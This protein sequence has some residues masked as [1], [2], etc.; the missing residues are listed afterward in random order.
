[1]SAIASNCESHRAELSALL[2]GES[3]AA[4]A[5]TTL[6]HVANCTEC[7]AFWNELRAFQAAVDGTRAG[8]PAARGADSVVATVIP[9]P[10]SVEPVVP[11]TAR[12]PGPR[13][14]TSRRHTRSRLVRTAAWAAAAALIVAVGVATLQPGARDG[15]EVALPT[16]SAADTPFETTP[17]SAPAP[18]T[19]ELDAHPESMNNARFVAIATELLESDHR[20]RRE[21]S[22]LLEQVDAATGPTDENPRLAR[23]DDRKPGN[24]GSDDVAAPVRASFERPLA[25]GD[26]GLY[27]TN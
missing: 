24:A 12:R 27:L 10:M 21:M 25:R 22:S 17:D 5:V 3:S 1:M 6:D 19:V 7:R 20:W 11:T 13:R 15:G 16:E 26:R 23:L 9:R 14:P 18:I 2:A 8:I 4:A